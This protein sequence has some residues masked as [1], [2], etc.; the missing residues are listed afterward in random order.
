MHFFPFIFPILPVHS[1]ILFHRFV[2]HS[3]NCILEKEF[4]LNNSTPPMWGLNSWLWYQESHAIQTEPARDPR[5]RIPNFLSAT[6][7]NTEHFLYFFP[8]S[9][10]FFPLIMINSLWKQKYFIFLKQWGYWSFHGM[11]GRIM[12]GPQHVYSLSPRS[13]L[14]YMAKSN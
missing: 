3:F 11:V 12:N 8:V 9:Y 6:T 1:F 10:H 4:F 14:G 5:K 2:K 13:T 7:A